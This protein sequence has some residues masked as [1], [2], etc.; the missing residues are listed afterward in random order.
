MAER[1]EGGTF[2]VPGKGSDAWNG[3]LPHHRQPRIRYNS[4]TTVKTLHFKA[5]FR[6]GQLS[7]GG[8]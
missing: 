6:S 5:S 2:G 1:E 7:G 4:T 3:T 8:R